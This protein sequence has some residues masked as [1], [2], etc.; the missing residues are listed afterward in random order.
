MNHLT[1]TFQTDFDRIALLPESGADHNAH[2]HDFLLRQLPEGCENALEIGCGTGAFSRLLATRSHHVLA[3]DLS[4]EM[5]R[6]AKAQSQP[7]PNLDF[8]IADARLTDFPAERFDCIVAIATLHHLPMQEMLAKLK[9][10]VKINGVILVLDLFQAQGLADICLGA[11]AIPTSVAL[12]LFKTGRLRP[13]KQTRKAWEEHA[14]HDSYVTLE[15]ARR[16]C[17]E[18]LPNAQVKRHLL[19]RYSIVWQKTASR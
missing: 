11:M 14:K 7:Y 15:Q 16:I 12:R 6:I 3:L 17:A 8:Q 5:I 2:Y 9:A 4:P 10:A 1:R 19:W 13:D 18:T